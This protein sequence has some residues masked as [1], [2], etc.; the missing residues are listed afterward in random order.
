MLLVCCL[1]VCLF[2]CLAVHNANTVLQ[3]G[4]R[5]TPD[6][7]VYLQP[8]DS[9]K[10]RQEL[11]MMQ[12]NDMNVETYAAQFCRCAARIA[13]SK[14]GTPVDSTAQAGYSVKGMI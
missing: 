2:V 10:A 7:W 1:F 6:V 8:G 3:M 14:V 9:R 11:A 5:Q 13:A 12:Q 4:T